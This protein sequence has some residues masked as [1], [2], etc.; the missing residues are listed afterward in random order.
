[1]W[2]FLVLLVSNA[3]SNKL[4]SHRFY[5]V[6]MSDFYL[7]FLCSLDFTGLLSESQ[8]GL[9]IQVTQCCSVI[10]FYVFVCYNFTMC[11]NKWWWWM[12]MMILLWWR[13]HKITHC[14]TTL[15]CQVTQSQINLH[16]MTAVRWWGRACQFTGNNDLTRTVSSSRRKKV[17]EAIHKRTLSQP[18]RTRSESSVMTT[19]AIPHLLRYASWASASYGAT[20]QSTPFS[21]HAF[22]AQHAGIVHATAVH[23]NHRQLHVYVHWAT[24]FH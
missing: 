1:V 23:F 17:N 10:C 21:R 4:I 6:T 15:Q 16:Y 22:T 20:M 14:R 19:W 11:E 12:M 5:C 13:Y 9:V 24:I 7:I 8:S 3:Q 2:I 18:N